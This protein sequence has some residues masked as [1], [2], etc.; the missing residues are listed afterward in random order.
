MDTAKVLEE[1]RAQRDRL[2]EVILSFERLAAG[3]SHR[4]RGRPP[5]WMAALT[6]TLAA[7]RKRGR[8][9]GSK[10]DPAA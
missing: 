7:P 4:R 1:P 10:N 5:A 3:Q 9:S 6:E 8:P 2:T